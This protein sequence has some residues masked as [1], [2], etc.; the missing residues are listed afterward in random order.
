MKI[1]Y[2]LTLTLTALPPLPTSRCCQAC[3]HHP[4]GCNHAAT[5]AAGAPSA[6]AALTPHCLLCFSRCRRRC[7]VAMPLLQCCCCNAAAAMLPPPVRYCTAAATVLPTLHF[8]QQRC[9][10][11]T[12]HA[13]AAA[14]A[15]LSQAA[16]DAATTTKAAAALLCCRRCC[17]CAAAATKL[18]PLGFCHHQRRAAAKLPPPLPGCHC[19]RKGCWL[20][21]AT[22]RPTPRVL[23]EW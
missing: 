9:H 3:R 5:L 14:K 19:S 6:A 18:P 2:N 15:A 22:T 17:C 21:Q 10:C 20:L 1:E 11:N 13:S 23:A 8:P 7:A 16:A 12:R 4:Q